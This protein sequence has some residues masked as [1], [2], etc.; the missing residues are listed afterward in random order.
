MRRAVPALRAERA[1]RRRAVFV[2]PA[3]N[4]FRDKSSHTRYRML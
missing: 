3:W 4:R 1:S 2:E